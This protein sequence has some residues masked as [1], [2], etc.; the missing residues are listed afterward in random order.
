ML[1]PR[2]KSAGHVAANAP[3]TEARKS[4]VATDPAAKHR[5]PGLPRRHTPVNAQLRGRNHRERD[6]PSRHDNW[7]DER[8][9]F[10]QFCMTCE[11][12]FV[13][14]DERFLY[15][16]DTCRRSDQNA[17][18]SGSRRHTLSSS[19]YGVYAG[20]EVGVPP[21]AKPEPRDIV[22]RATPSRPTSIHLSNTPPGSPDMKARHSSALSALRSLNIGPSSPPSPTG[23]NGSS[24]WPFG[25][26]MATSPG[27]S[28]T[29]PSA[30][31]LSSTLDGD[32][33]YGGGGYMC[34]AGPDRPLPSRHPGTYSRPKSIEL[35]TPVVGR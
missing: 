33:Y 25:R 8:E 22:P 31:Y 26:S 27:N 15:C 17:S 32:Y 29:R 23:S 16:S 28:Y 30:P 13:A 6:R 4:V 19:Q 21:S 10:P 14:H 34:D 5:R 1:P 20:C 18:S 11:K 7:D 35:V 9:S 12:Q 24:I 2:K 3:P